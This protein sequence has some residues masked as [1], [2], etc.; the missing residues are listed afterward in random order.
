MR[1]QDVCNVEI[2]VYCPSRPVFSSYVNCAE[3]CVISSY[4]VLSCMCLPI[5]VEII[6]SSSKMFINTKMSKFHGT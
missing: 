6:H 4:Y 5:H 2:Y 3:H 1:E